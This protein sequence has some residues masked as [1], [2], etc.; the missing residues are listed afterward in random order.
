[1]VRNF[2]CCKTVCD[3]PNILGFLVAKAQATSNSS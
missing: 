1:M 2:A 3:R